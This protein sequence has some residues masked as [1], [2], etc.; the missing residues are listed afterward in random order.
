VL[1]TAKCES[2]GRVNKFHTL[3]MAH[4]VSGNV[5]DPFWKGF[6]HT[7]IHR[8]MAPDVLHQLYQGVFKHVIGWCQ[9]VVR[10]KELDCRIQTLPHTQGLRHFKTGIT[11]MNQISG[12]ERKDMAKV[13]LGCLVGIMAPQGIKAVKALLD[14]IYLAQYP[15]HDT[16]T[17]KYMQDALDTFHQ[18]KKYFINVG[19]HPDLNIPKL[20]SLLHYIDSIK[21]FGTTDNY[22]T[23]MF[24]RLHINFAKEGWRA[25]NHR[26]EFPQMIQWLSR[27]E[28]MTDLRTLVE[29]RIQDAHSP[30]SSPLSPSFPT[31]RPISISKAPAHPDC[32][33]SSIEKTHNAPFFSH[34]LKRYLASFLDAPMGDR[35]LSNASLPIESVDVYTNFRFSPDQ[36]NEDNEV[37]DIVKAIPS[38][39]TLPN[40]RFDTVVV[41]DTDEAEATALHGLFLFFLG[42]YHFLTHT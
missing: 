4:G 41:M 2:K 14:F 42:N 15:N 32:S 34:H 33:I 31:R 39:K 17:L 30:M 19:C 28:K 25:S 26:N 35:Q 20:H 29:S 11:N 38:S 37:S 10:E 21:L 5:F 27:Q 36:L 23:E 24:E 1:A 40:G 18:H 6:P 12:S 22:N 3:A 16:E 13:L 8:I 9:S 7:D